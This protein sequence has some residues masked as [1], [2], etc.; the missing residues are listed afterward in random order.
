MRP[1]PQ[2]ELY[3]GFFRSPAGP[4][5]GIAIR[6]LRDPRMGF[7]P[8]RAP[9]AAITQQSNCWNNPAVQKAIADQQRAA[10]RWSIVGER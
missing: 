7:G 8:P 3:R 1:F 6:D 10:S 4:C 2:G 9:E 5:I